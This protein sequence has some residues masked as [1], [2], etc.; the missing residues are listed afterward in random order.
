MLLRPIITEKTTKQGEGQYVF[1]VERRENKIEVK[2]EL[3]R[4]Y[5]VEVRKVGIINTPGKIRRLGRFIGKKP[6]IK[7][8]VVILKKGQ[9]IRTF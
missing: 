4:L 2:K 1:V 5:K 3:E 9:K 7:K 6:G 8:A